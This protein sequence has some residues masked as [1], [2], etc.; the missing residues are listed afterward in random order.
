ML[1]KKSSF[2]IVNINE[3]N[4]NLLSTVHSDE[5][6]KAL[7]SGIP[8]ELANSSGLIWNSQF[9]EIFT[10]SSSALVHACWETLNGQP[11]LAL[12][13]G[14]HHAVK[15]RGYGFNP[16]NEIAIAVKSIH[17][18]Q[19]KVKIAVLDSDIH[20]G[21]GLKEILHNEPN[22]LI[23]DIWNKMLE[24]WGDP[25]SKGSYISSFVT[26]TKEYFQTLRESL[27]SIKK[28]AP[29]LVIY[30]SGADVF[31][32]DR[33]G[34]IKGFDLTKYTDREK[35]VMENL[36]GK[37]CLVFGGGY[38]VYEESSDYTIMELVDLHMS[39]IEIFSSLH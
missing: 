13:K 20:L 34:G 14:G 9:F 37:T 2:D 6:L 16:V 32:K 10:N 29:E 38:A 30:H 27:A 21:N 12:T 39:S 19:P 1:V 18:K 17:K 25:N 11:S 28:Y 33:F 36:A 15:S 22:C 35:L 7:R 24:K 31:E 3:K 8:N 26:T 5:Y 4:A 23:I